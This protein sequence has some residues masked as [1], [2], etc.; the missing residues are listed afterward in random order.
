MQRLGRF[1]ET[2]FRTRDAD[3]E[4]VHN[5]RKSGENGFFQAPAVPDTT[6]GSE[7]TPIDTAL[8][9]VIQRTRAEMARGE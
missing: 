1:Q 2:K 5:R 8:V 3:D 6:V 7:K 9:A 4:S